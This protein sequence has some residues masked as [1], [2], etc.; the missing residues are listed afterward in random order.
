M[1]RADL[2]ESDRDALKRA[3]NAARSESPARAK[4]IDA[5]LRDPSRSWDEIAK[6]AASC[7]QTSNLGLMPWQPPP[8][9]IANIDAA[10]AASDDEPRRGRNAAATL[11]QQMLDA[12]VSRFEPDPMT[13]L[14]EAE[15]QSM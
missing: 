4:Q 15:H 7:V 3:L 14:A 11:L 9:Q 12:G 5:M 6:F 1:A 10:L 8:C 13:A 2:S